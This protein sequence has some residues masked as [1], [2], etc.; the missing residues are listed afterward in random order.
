MTY[1]EARKAIEEGKF[2]TRPGWLKGEGA[3][4]DAEYIGKDDLGLF[5]K[6]GG[7]SKWKTTTTYQPGG[8]YWKWVTVTADMPQPSIEELE[9][10]DWCEF[11]VVDTLECN[12]EY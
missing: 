2:I 5:W 6:T 10:T 12:D 11:T 3:D 7:Y 4:L 1:T 8:Y 9:A